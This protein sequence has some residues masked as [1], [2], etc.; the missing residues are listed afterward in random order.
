[1]LYSFFCPANIPVNSAELFWSCYFDNTIA[2][3]FPTS[4]STPSYALGSFT[5]V[6][7]LGDGASTI[8]ASFGVLSGGT[9]TFMTEHIL[10]EVGITDV[11]KIAEFGSI[12][13]EPSTAPGGKGKQLVIE[14]KSGFTR[15]GIT[16]SEPRSSMLRYNSPMG[17]PLQACMPA[18]SWLRYLII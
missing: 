7:S 4:F 2:H 10:D 16:R 9:P 6:D 18:L 1:M 3:V 17:K 13:L 15:R 11:S 8:N 14:Q 5:G 12:T